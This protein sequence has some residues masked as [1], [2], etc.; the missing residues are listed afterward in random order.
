MHKLHGIIAGIAIRGL[1]F[2]ARRKPGERSGVSPPSQMWATRW[3]DTHRSPSY[4]PGLTHGAY[5]K[6]YG[7]TRSPSCP[8]IGS[9]IPKLHGGSSGQWYSFTH[10]DFQTP[11]KTH[12]TECH[13]GLASV[14]FV[15]YKPVIVRHV[16][17][18]YR[19]WA[20]EQNV[21]RTTR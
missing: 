14:E 15:S 7:Q 19:C 13:E 5:A 11:R 16:V 10:E 17:R 20:H 12:L 21:D 18:Q 8:Q 1:T 3:A 4:V 9:Q 6:S 2:P